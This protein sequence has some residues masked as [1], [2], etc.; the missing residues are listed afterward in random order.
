MKLED[1]LTEVERLDWD[2]TEPPRRKDPGHAA[3]LASAFLP[4][5]VRRLR[6]AVLAI[7]VNHTELFRINHTEETPLPKLCR[8]GLLLSKC[9]V[10]KTLREIEEPE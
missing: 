6:L 3:D 4:E 10:Y 8:C 1:L 7:R 2:A 5:L 9:Q